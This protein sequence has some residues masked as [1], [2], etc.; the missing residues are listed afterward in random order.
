MRDVEVGQ[1]IALIP[2]RSQAVYSVSAHRAGDGSEG[3]WLAIC[4]R[5]FNKSKACVYVRVV[6]FSA[7]IA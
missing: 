3:I 6:Y 2:S 5:S 1:G 4:L 7:D